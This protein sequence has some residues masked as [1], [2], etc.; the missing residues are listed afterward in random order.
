MQDWFVIAT[1]PSLTE[2]DAEKAWQAAQE[3]GGRVIVVNDNYRLLP[4]AD[5]CYACDKGWWKVHLERVKQS[6]NGEKWMQYHDDG[7][8]RYAD[9]NGITAV[10]GKS[11]SGLG[12]GFIR[13]GSNSG[14]QAIC[15]AHHL[16][17]E[18]YFGDSG[19][20]LRI[21]LLGFDMGKSGGKTHWFGDHPPGLTNGDCAKFVPQFDQLAKDLS[22]KGVEVLNC[23][24][25]T[26]LT[27]F[28]RGTIDDPSICC[29]Q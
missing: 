27:Q 9:E 15:L 12:D 3:S 2:G 5:I 21:I 7:I 1:G 10:E 28:T 14:H 19:N 11:G 16:F 6:F 29:I 4:D 22:A 20:S 25:K 18:N 24:R 17:A 8:K 13:H 26:R 23:S